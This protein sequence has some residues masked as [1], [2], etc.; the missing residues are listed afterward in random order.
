MRFFKATGLLVLGLLMI[1]FSLKKT[2]YG[3]ELG[4]DLSK[5]LENESKFYDATVNFKLLI[6]GIFS[7]L[8]GI[9]FL[10]SELG[11]IDIAISE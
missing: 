2:S 9:I 7:L 11:F 1:Y 8:V 5:N 4:T 3:K 10:L 6:F